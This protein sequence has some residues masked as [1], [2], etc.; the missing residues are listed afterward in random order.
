MRPAIIVHGGS[1][2]IPQEEHQ[3]HQ[4]GC[5]QAA[6]IGFAILRDGGSALEAVEAAVVHL[7]DDPTFDAGTG[8]HLNRAGVVQLDAGMMDGRTLQVGAIAAIERVRNPIQVARLLLSSDHNM[9]VAEGATA[10]AEQAGIPLITPAELIVPR[11]QKRYERGLREGPPD[12]QKVFKQPDG[13][14]GAVAIDRHGDLVAGTS[15]GGTLFK[16]VGRVGDSPL[17]GC[18]YFADNSSAAASSTGHGE[19]IIR[20]QLARTAADFAKN[21]ALAGAEEELLFARHAAEAAIATLANRVNG[22]GGVI[23]IDRYG[24][25]GYAYNTPHMARGFM[26]EGMDEPEVAI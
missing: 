12:T 25:I 18:G 6:H 11:E 3:A 17:P 22:R 14:V 19:S 4:A 21:L 26:A 5:F 13:T 9:F 2:D 20:V 7:E 16:P 15:T 10:W 8:S 23:M 1:W 24:R